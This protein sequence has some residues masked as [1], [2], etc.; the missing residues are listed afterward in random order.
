MDQDWTLLEEFS[1]IS[2]A[3]CDQESMKYP[4]V[5]QEK[6]QKIKM[7]TSDPRLNMD[8]LTTEIDYNNPPIF[9]KMNLTFD[10]WET[11]SYYYEKK[12][13]YL[14]ELEDDDKIKGIIELEAWFI[15]LIHP[16]PRNRKAELVEVWSK[17]EYDKL[18]NKY[19]SSCPIEFRKVVS[20][21]IERYIPNNWKEMLNGNVKEIQ[22][23]YKTITPIQLVNL[24]RAKLK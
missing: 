7:I 10:Q 5:N 9:P 19:T 20:K 16:P 12:I 15:M 18:K 17:R 6:I 8:Q 2:D 24:S 13:E 21:N 1:I 3:L 23:K 11:A 14:C 4:T 22:M